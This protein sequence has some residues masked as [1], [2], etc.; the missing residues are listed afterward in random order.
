MMFR[1]VSA[2]MRWPFTAM[3]PR[4]SASSRPRWRPSKLNGV[5]RV[6]AVHGGPASDTTLMIRP[7]DALVA[8]VNAIGRQPGTPRPEA[9]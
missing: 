9:G 3:T 5:L 6:I 8:G 7:L 4:P 1:V 2:T